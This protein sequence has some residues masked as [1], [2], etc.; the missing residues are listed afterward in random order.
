MSDLTGK[1]ITIPATLDGNNW[2]PSELRNYGDGLPPG[3]MRLLR[4]LADET[5]RQHPPRMDEPDEFGAMVEAGTQ[6]KGD[7][8]RERRRLVKH[9]TCGAFLWSDDRGR[10][11]AWSELIDPRPVD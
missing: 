2:S 7:S 8:P 6:V 9:T 4:W 5:E 11:Y 3:G 1:T 10:T